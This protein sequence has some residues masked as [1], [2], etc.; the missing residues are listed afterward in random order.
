MVAIYSNFYAWAVLAL[1]LVEVA[2]RR[3]R[4]MFARCAVVLGALAIT[5]VPVWLFLVTGLAPPGA[6]VICKRQFSRSITSMRCC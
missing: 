3:Q 4:E 6:Q 1:L 2:I 5:Y